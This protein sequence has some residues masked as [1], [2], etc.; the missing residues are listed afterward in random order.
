MKK[1]INKILIFLH[2]KKEYGFTQ[3]MYRGIPVIQRED[4]PAN[5]IGFLNKKTGIMQIVDI[6]S[7]EIKTIDFGKMKIK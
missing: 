6:E 2:L 1:F 7:R 5:K 3:L 4:F